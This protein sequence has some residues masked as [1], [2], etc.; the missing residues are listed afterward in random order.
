MTFQRH[1]LSFQNAAVAQLCWLVCHLALPDAEHA[2]RPLW[3]IAQD[4]VEFDQIDQIEADN[5]LKLNQLKLIVPFDENQHH[6]S[7]D[8]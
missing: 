4:L 2:I 8:I 3:H 6:R 1:S 7:L 5:F